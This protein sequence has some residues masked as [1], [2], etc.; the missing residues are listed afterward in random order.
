MCIRD[1][2]TYYSLLTKFKVKSFADCVAVAHTIRGDH[3]NV[4][5]VVVGDYNLDTRADCCK[6]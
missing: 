1:R 6:I 3:T 5:G 4:V 2:C